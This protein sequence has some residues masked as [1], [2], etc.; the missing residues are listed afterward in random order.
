MAQP[1]K[2]PPPAKTPQERP[3]VPISSL[4]EALKYV[5]WNPERRGVLL[6]LQP[7][8]V[9]P[10]MPER[11]PGDWYS[12]HVPPT[13]LLTPAEGK[14]IGINETAA[15]FGRKVVKVGSL[16][17]LAPTEMVV[18]NT[19]LPEKRDTYASLRSHEKSALFNGSLTK[20]QWQQMGSEQ[21]L[22]MEGLDPEQ[23]KLLDSM[24]PNPLYVVRMKRNPAQ[25]RSF[26]FIYPDGDSPQPGKPRDPRFLLTDAQR[27]SIRLRLNRQVS[28]TLPHA[29]DNQQD[30]GGQWVDL[31][32]AR[33]EQQKEQVSVA[34]D[35]GDYD[36]TDAFGVEIRSKVP[37]K[38]KQGQ[39]NF[40]SPALDP[41]V[42]LAEVKTVGEAIKRVR[43]ATRLELTV[44]GRVAGL[45]IGGIGLE[46]SVRS[47]DLLKALCW[48]ICGAFRQVGNLYHLTEDVVGLNTRRVFINEWIQM[49]DMERQ[50]MMFKAQEK[51]REH[52]PLNMINF[53]KDDPI[54]L[55]TEMSSKIEE[56]WKNGRWYEGVQVRTADLPDVALNQVKQSIE[57]YQRNS[58][59]N[60]QQVLTDR[61]NV[62]VNLVMTAI[63]PGVGEIQNVPLNTD[64]GSMLPRPTQMMGPD[65]KPISSDP[66]TIPAKMKDGGILCV[67]LKTKE[68]AERAV[69]VAKQRNLKKLWVM[70]PLDYA[71]TK[72]ILEATI[73]AGKAQGIEVYAVL[74]LMQIPEDKKPLGT[75][76]AEIRDINVLG[77]TASQANKRLGSGGENYNFWILQTIFAQQGETIRPDAPLTIPMLK[78]R[79]LEVGKIPGLAGLVL[80]DVLAPGYQSTENMYIPIGSSDYGYTL[81]RRLAFIRKNG[82]DPIDLT[83]DMFFGGV[84]LRIPMFEMQRQRWV[85]QADGSYGPDPN[86]TSPLKEWNTIRHEINLKTLSELYKQVRKELPTLPILAADA[87]A[88]IFSGTWYASWDDA[89]KIP[90]SASRNMFVGQ[91]SGATP[92]R[93]V[94]IARLSSKIAYGIVS[95]PMWEIHLPEIYN[96]GRQFEADS[97][98]GMA[99]RLNQ[100]LVEEAKHSATWDGLVIDLSDLPL[101]KVEELILGA[102]VAPNASQKISKTP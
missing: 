9:S 80:R 76:D 39:L 54:T 102:I 90:R 57:E 75:V 4:E 10:W 43:E 47:G 88:F 27:Q 1:A 58:N 2:T 23:K 34:G 14:T 96:R 51:I 86:Y 37:S 32:S 7:A 98:P 44:D 78:Q 3:P 18:L 21:G 8:S 16:T 13:S 5:G 101:K 77:E 53:A 24:I 69:W 15:Y 63:I 85:A 29:G 89:E 49:G 91:P 64:I 33:M 35:W 25:P 84:N 100:L 87:S 55:P 79:L 72:P 68:E 82:Y 60:R 36:R 99:Q 17:V 6:A 95:I 81:D 28:M 56:K 40:D 70:L 73:E 62:S 93:P 59:S 97:V 66:V 45:A 30:F 20:A 52:N 83:P 38:L 41:K 42:S 31:N 71:P 92:K 94:E 26:D 12:P 74:R 67:A 61:V 65:Q 19:R 48:A 46:G 22:G 11:K 50:E